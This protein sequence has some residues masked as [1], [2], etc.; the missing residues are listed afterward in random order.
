MNRTL[1]AAAVVA[2]LALVAVGSA[3]ADLISVQFTIGQDTNGAYSTYA[4]YD[5]PAY[6]DGKLLATQ[7]TW[8]HV[9]A[10]TGSGLLQTGGAAFGG[11]IDFGGG[12]T[13]GS[14]NWGAGMTYFGGWSGRAAPSGYPAYMS[15]LESY[16]GDG[17]VVMGVRVNGLAAGTY[18]VYA[19]ADVQGA[20]Q[21]VEIGLN[22]TSYTASN[23]VLSQ[24][25]SSHT[26]NG[27]WYAGTSSVAGDYAYKDVTVTGT[28]DYITVLASRGTNPLMSGLQIVQ[29]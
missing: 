19:L 3:S 29:L 7:T 25:M 2:M 5:S 22:L 4:G 26:A 23:T 20:P 17:G 6:A 1:I 18:R 24:Y 8:N 14:I 15:Y 11:A 28:N 9:G 16:A 12:T 27:A 13:T 10:D 21:S